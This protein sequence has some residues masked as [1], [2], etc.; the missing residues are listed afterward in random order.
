M[1]L[2]SVTEC[3]RIIHYLI[4]SY[5]NFMMENISKESLSFFKYLARG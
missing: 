5:E 3:G 2:E 1:S 4:T